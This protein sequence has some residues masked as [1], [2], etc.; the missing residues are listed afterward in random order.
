[1]QMNDIDDFDWREF[2]EEDVEWYRLWFEFL[3]ISDK[4]KWSDDVACNFDIDYLKDDLCTF[5]AWWPEH[6]YLFR[7]LEQPTIDVMTSGQSCVADDWSPEDSGSVALLVHMWATKIELRKA[8]EEILKKYHKGKPGRPE[9]IDDGDFYNL[10]AR[11]DTDMLKKT[12]AVY[13]AFKKPENKGMVLW[14]IEEEASKEIPLID[15]TSKSATYYWKLPE[16]GVDQ[17]I[18]ENRRKSQCSTVKRYLKCAEDILKNV[19]EGRFPVYEIN[20]DK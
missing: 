4:T 15:K 13:K 11:P 16:S 20:I 12:L 3:K 6:K 10:Y 2:T 18:L 8:F 9:F 19:V 1:M 5:D 17:Y 14:Q 7:K